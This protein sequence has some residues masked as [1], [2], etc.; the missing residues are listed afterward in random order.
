MND[1]AN[2]EPDLPL[3]GP[4]EPPF[5]HVMTY[6]LK[7]A[8]G[9]APRSWWS[10][11][12]LV[13]RILKAE[14]P[15]VLCTQEG[16]FRQL[17]E[18]RDGLDGYDWV[19]LGRGG[20]SRS[21]ATAV[22]WDASRLAP[23]AYDHVWLSRRP[24]LIG[25]R[26][27]GAGTV[28]ML[29]WVRFEDKATGENFHVADVHLDHRSERAR[30]KGAQ[31]CLDLMRRFAGPA[32]LAGDFNCEPGSK[33]HAL[34]TEGGLHDAWETAEERLT[35]DWATYNRW[36]PAPAAG[37]RLDWILTKSGGPRQRLRVHRAAVNAYSEQGLVPSDHWPVQAVL[38]VG[39]R[40]LQ[41]K[42]ARRD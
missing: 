20:G 13:Q 28:R 17:M 19:H 42:A 6:N 1:A 10:R 9:R 25:S 16:R 35:P 32:V 30:R 29:T 15:T 21:E 31:M 23:V 22:F 12:P 24:N 8:S 37:R 33:T 39:W 27:W 2:A 38:T 3:I 7:S 5:L 4:V 36:R 26:A 14:R 41:E 11:R 34:L 18:L 40:G